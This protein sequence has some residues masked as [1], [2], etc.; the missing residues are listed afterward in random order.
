MYIYYDYANTE[1]RSLVDYHPKL[2]TEQQSSIHNDY[3]NFKEINPDWT[4]SIIKGVLINKKYIFLLKYIDIIKF[5][6]ETI[7]SKQILK[8]NSIIHINL[9]GILF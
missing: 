8:T 6:Q 7:L 5:W 1:I 3:R 9:A 2:H 4:I